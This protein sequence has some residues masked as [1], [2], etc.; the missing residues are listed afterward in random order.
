VDLHVDAG[1]LTAIV[2]A[3][4]SGKTTLLNVLSGLDLPSAGQ[5]VVA[6]HDLL[7]MGRRE[8]RR[9]RLATCGFVWQ[10]AAH[11]LVPYLTAAEN[12]DLP[13]RLAGVGGRDRER[14]STELLELVGIGDCAGLRPAMLSGGQQQRLAV[15][16]AMAN[17]PR[18]LFCD[19]PTG[20]LDTQSSHEVYTALRTVN[21]ERG[22]TVLVVTHDVA[23][24]SE[25]RRTIAMRDGTTATETLRGVAGTAGHA[26]HA[27]E[28]A[29]LDRIGRLQLPQEFI[30]SLDLQRRVRL[31]LEP[32]HIQVWP[33][34]QAPHE[35]Q[36]AAGA[37][38][39]TGN[40]HPPHADRQ[41]AGRHKKVQ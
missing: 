27:Q 41:N 30:E 11:N 10:Q 8:R 9:Y 22:V 18:V 29:V 26:P 14:R 36:H 13:Q 2:G 4:G 25:V 21:E 12:V 20:E 39:R 24:S 23:V 17:E 28:Y 37:D 38:S 7:A 15:A 5:A 31:E 33:P 6:G 1:E 16:V 40:E 32:D 19:E 35:G 3:S 34:E